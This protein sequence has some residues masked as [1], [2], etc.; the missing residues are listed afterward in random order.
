MPSGGEDAFWGCAG[1]CPD[2]VDCPVHIL[3]LGSGVDNSSRAVAYG[4]PFGFPISET[5]F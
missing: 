2:P 4:Q 5:P 3:P 1:C